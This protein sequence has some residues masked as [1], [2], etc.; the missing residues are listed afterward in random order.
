MDM[1]QQA[2]DRTARGKALFRR[3]VDEV[4]NQG[5]LAT[6]DELFAP[7]FVGH[8]QLPPAP[9]M[10]REGVKALFSMYHSAFSGFQAEIEDLIAEGDKVVGL[11]TASGTHTGSFA[12]I[13]ATGKRVR[14]RT[15]DIFR[16]A[17]DQ[18]VEHWAMPDQYGLRRQL[19]LMSSPGEGGG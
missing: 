1:A 13:P 15:M 11:L 17:G 16:I 4:M 3:F 6:I 14:F 12:G 5:K 2:Q 9:P 7:D 18:I 10:N 19:G 8:V